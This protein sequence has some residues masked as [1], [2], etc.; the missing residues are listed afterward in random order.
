MIR[1]CRCAIIALVV[2]PGLT[3]VSG[4]HAGERCEITFG[5]RT[6][7]TIVY[8]FVSAS[9]S[10]CWGPDILG[11]HVYL[12]DE[13]TVTRLVQ[14]GSYDFLAIDERGD[15]Y[16]FWDFLV[17]DERSSRITLGASDREGGWD[18]PLLANVTIVNATEYR[19]ESVYFSPADRTAGGADLLARA[20]PLL[21]D[22]N[23]SFLV[24][25]GSDPMRFSVHSVDENGREYGFNF[26]LSS[27]SLKRL[28]AIEMIDRQ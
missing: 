2:I 21:P 23:I 5:N 15:A 7:R 16:L 22:A 27:A 8:L 24:P 6:G 3:L 14:P 28:Y 20:S 18:L 9:E 4:V 10:S 26:S 12:Y 17:D 25:V 19:M 13:D 1:R 11:T